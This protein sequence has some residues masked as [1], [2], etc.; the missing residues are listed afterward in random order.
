[1]Q[2]QNCIAVSLYPTYSYIFYDVD[3]SYCQGIIFV[4]ALW[5]A[6]LTTTGTWSMQWSDSD[7]TLVVLLQQCGYKPVST[8]LQCHEVL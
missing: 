1:M 8:P 3:Q 4:I 2:Y 6:K 7:T 5:H